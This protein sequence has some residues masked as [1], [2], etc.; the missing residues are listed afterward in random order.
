MKKKEWAPGIIVI[1]VIIGI[2]AGMRVSNHL[3]TFGLDKSVLQG[4]QN[5]DAEQTIRLCLYY[6]N[7][8]QEEQ[9]NQLMLDGC[10]RYEPKTLSDVKLLDIEP[11]AD[12]SE[13]E[14]GFHVVYNWRT[15]WAPWWEDDRTNSVDFQLVQQD[16]VW[17]IKSIGNG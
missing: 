6:V 3:R 11:W 4:E 13:Q 14:Q 1:V 16:G 5:P 7:R 17:K 10:E 15:F 12:N 8:G 2:V 9:A